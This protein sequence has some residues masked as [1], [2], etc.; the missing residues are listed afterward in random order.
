MHTDA[1]ALSLVHIGR[2]NALLGGAD[3]IAAACLLAQRIQ[4]QMPRENAVCTC[5]NVQLIGR[6]AAC[7]QTVHLAENGLRVYN[8]TR[9]DDIYTIRIQNTGRN[10]L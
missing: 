3:V 9:S 4:F 8:N 6:N 7:I 1:D 5:V 10:Q 2:A